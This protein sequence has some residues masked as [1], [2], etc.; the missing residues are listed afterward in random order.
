MD[1]PIR[2]L[3]EDLRGVW[4]IPGHAG[5]GACLSWVQS[6]NHC[7]LGY[8]ESFMFRS[9]KL[10]WHS[11][12][13]ASSCI[14]WDGEVG[15]PSDALAFVELGLRE[16]ARG[17]P[18]TAV[19]RSLLTRVSL[20]SPA[21]AITCSPSAHPPPHRDRSSAASLPSRHRGHH[22]PILGHQ[23]G[24]HVPA[25]PGHHRSGKL[26]SSGGFP[27]PQGGSEGTLAMS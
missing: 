24:L 10:R 15:Q 6:P 18:H 7:P 23:H 11:F 4:G 3:S 8:G 17:S 19:P 27:N 22:G 2:C 25:K 9:A 20:L 16:E 12:Q 5:A 1:L 26:G 21:P 14:H 13:L